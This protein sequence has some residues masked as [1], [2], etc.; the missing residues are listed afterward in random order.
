MSLI[1]TKSTNLK[2]MAELRLPEGAN[3]ILDRIHRSTLSR[4]RTRVPIY[5]LSDI[6]AD[7]DVHNLCYASTEMYQKMEASDESQDSF[8]TPAPQ[9]SRLPGTT[10][11]EVLDSHI[12]LLNDLMD[13]T[14]HH[15]LEDDAIFPFAFVV[16][17]SA[18][19]RRHGATVVVLENDFGSDDGDNDGLS[20]SDWSVDEI[21]TSLVAL[22]GICRALVMDEDDWPDIRENQGRP[23]TRTGAPWYV[24]TRSRSWSPPS[25]TS[26]MRRWG[27]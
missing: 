2:S 8:I 19:W 11:Q 3:R 13:G 4:E 15:R 10:V 27:A 26:E 24:S 21:E 20:E 18:L 25:I 5:A 6:F 7:E 9:A 12:A 14:E 23:T 22:G 17:E 16:I 1:R